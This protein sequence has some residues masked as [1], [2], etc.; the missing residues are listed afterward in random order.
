MGKSGYS[1]KISQCSEINTFDKCNCI[2][3]QNKLIKVNR[4]LKIVTLCNQIQLRA[5]EEISLL[6]EICQ[7]IVNTGG[8]ELAW[9]GYARKTKIKPWKMWLVRVRTKVMR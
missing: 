1:E 3:V 6:N 2:N 8:Y 5:H 4:A 7:I 9:V